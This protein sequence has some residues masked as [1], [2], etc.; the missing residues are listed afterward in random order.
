MGLLLGLDSLGD[1]QACTTLFGPTNILFMAIGLVTI[2]E[3]ARVLRRSPRKLWLFCAAVSLG[4][5]VLG[6]CWGV[7]LLIALPHGLGNVMLGPIWRPTYPLVLP[8]LMSV[9]GS[10]LGTGAGAGLH[11]LG[12]SRKSLGTTIFGTL[13]LIGFSLG[14]AAL[15]GVV[16]ACWGI[17]LAAFVSDFVTWWQLGVAI[18]DAKI[19]HNDTLIGLIR[20]LRGG[21]DPADSVMQHQHGKHRIAS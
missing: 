14:G 1:M 21:N 2:P 3:A 20:R 15:A 19:G 9:I 10:A 17:A 11:A 8:I 5:A 7:L 12:A 6:L 16:G 4:L 13:I 18:R